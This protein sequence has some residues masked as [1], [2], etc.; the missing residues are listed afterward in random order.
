MF[1]DLEGNIF[2]DFNPT[3]FRHLLEQLRQIKRNPSFQFSPPP[4]SSASAIRSFNRMLK[5]LGLKE[6]QSTSNEI[7][8]M[9]IGGDRIITRSETL[10][11][12]QAKSLIPKTSHKRNEIFVDID[13]WLFRYLLG[14]LREQKT[15]KLI[16]VWPPSSQNL[17][18]VNR[19]LPH[20]Q[21]KRQ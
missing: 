3:L 7:V 9:N 19:I 11:F 1:Q 21:M 6:R 14:R 8:L 13:P 15:N 18:T 10:N 5:K 20:L 2:L 4:S 12:T 16:Y 17:I